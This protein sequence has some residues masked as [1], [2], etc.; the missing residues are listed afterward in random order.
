MLPKR[1]LPI[2]APFL[3]S[4][5]MVTLMTAVITAANTGIDNGFLARWGK[6]FT[7]AWPVAFTFIFLFSKRIAALAQRICSA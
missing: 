7:I 2:V 1:F 5:L 3:M 6:A 4:V